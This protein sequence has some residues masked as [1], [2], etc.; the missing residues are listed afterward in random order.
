MLITMKKHLC[1]LFFMLLWG[2]AFSQSASI[3]ESKTAIEGKKYKKALKKIE[4]GLE[5]DKTLY[6]LHYLKAWAELEIALETED[7]KEQQRAYRGVLKSLEKA[8]EKDVNNEYRARYQWLY[9]RFTNEY[10]K[11]GVEQHY[12]MQYAKAIPFLETAWLLSKDTTAYA[13]MGLCHYGNKDLNKAMPILHSAAQ[14]MHGSWEPQAQKALAD[15]KNADVIGKNNPLF[16]LEIFQVLGKHYAEKNEED[17]AL[18]YLEMGLEIF[19]KDIK[20]TRTVTAVINQ[21]VD[22]LKREVG[23][24]TAIK[25][26]VDLGLFYEPNNTKFL[27]SQNAYFLARLGYVLKRNDWEEARKFDS[28]FWQD[29]QQL[30]ARGARNSKDIFLNPDSAAFQSNCLQYFM[31][32]DNHPAL[33]YYFYKWYPLQFSTPAFNEIGLQEILGN[34]PVF[35]SQRLLYAVANDAVKRFP[36]NSRIKQ[37]R[38]DLY[39]KWLSTSIG[40]NSWNYLFAWNTSMFQDFPKKKFEL[41][42][43]QQLLFERGIDSFLGYGDLN[44]A[45]KFLH[46]LQ[47]NFPK[48]AQLDS[49]KKRL[50]LRDFEIRYKGSSISNPKSGTGGKLPSTGWTGLSKRCMVGTMPAETQQKIVDRVNYFRQ[51]AGIKQTIEIDEERRQKCQE[52]SVMYAPVGVFTR[53]PTPETHICYSLKAAEAAA[54]SQVIKDPN[55][56]IAITVLTSDIKSEELF[57]RQY[58]LAPNARGIGFGS[59]ENN[60]VVWMVEPNETLNKVDSAY[61]AKRFISW[62]PAGYCPRMF[63]FQKWSISG[64]IDFEGV[65]VSIESK[66]FGKLPC[67]VKAD[68]APMVSYPTLVFEPKISSNF[69]E[70]IKNEE[71]ITVTMSRKDKVI[72]SYTTILLDT[73]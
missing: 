14:M 58:I 7:S 6:E 65:T 37:I 3:I 31:A 27:E 66:S 4:K 57:N 63:F 5:K 72:H 51:H 33:V 44:T 43:D 28:S 21:K 73:K 61:Y 52:A 8:P 10:K 40:P 56:A 36:K 22:N 23:L 25:K 24:N 39:K 53:V 2:S 70:S 64:P 20:L 49:F 19:P 1:I 54:Y 47:E 15:N 17:S 45:W 60:T 18:I 48:N 35:V 9:T 32:A 55:P 38:Y 67:T 59:S 29:K 42:A 69:Y 16:N 71:A 30:W 46:L 13:L 68:K 41:T 26:W 12:R 11:E 62:P 34:P 50:A